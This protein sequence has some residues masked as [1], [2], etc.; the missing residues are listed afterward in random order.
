MPDPRLTAV[1]ELIERGDLEL[2]VDGLIALTRGLRAAGLRGAGLA[3][4]ALNLSGRLADARRERAD[5]LLSPENAGVARNEIRMGLLALCDDIEAAAATLPPESPRPRSSDG[6]RLEPEGAIPVFV[7][8]A[9]E[10]GVFCDRLLAA[11]APYERAGE[12]TVWAS[13]PSQPGARGQE[14]SAAKLGRAQIAILLLS[15]DFLVSRRCM[16]EEV[17]AAEERQ[18]RGECVIVPIVIRACRYDRLTIGE[19][20]VI[21][22]G[23]KPVSEH[24]DADRAWFEVTQELDRVLSGLKS[25]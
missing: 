25:G 11:L 13:R 18:A 9:Q 5:G 15:R 19:L 24:E 12:L 4:R 22:P 14:E 8:Y 23:G 1:R 2:A 7:S 6:R 21:L 16:D 17:A 20:Q 10:D 3:N